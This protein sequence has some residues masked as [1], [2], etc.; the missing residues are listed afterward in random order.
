MTNQEEFQIKI[1]VE[2]E[3]NGFLVKSLESF[4]EI[5][6]LFEFRKRIF[7]DAGYVSLILVGCRS[8]ERPKSPTSPR[9]RGFIN[10]QN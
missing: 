3:K 5:E 1:K 4:Q 6:R 8:L 2:F 10:P 7:I 9:S